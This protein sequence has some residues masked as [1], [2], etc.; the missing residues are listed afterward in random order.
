MRAFDRYLVFDHDCSVKEA[1]E[2]DSALHLVTHDD[3]YPFRPSSVKD[4][5]RAPTP[6]PT[7]T[8]TIRSL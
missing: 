4:L 6:T 5:T 1:L 3:A 2:L 8:P 7:P